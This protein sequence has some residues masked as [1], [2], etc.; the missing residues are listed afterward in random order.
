M[1]PF[2]NITPKNKEKLLRSL[3]AN[4]H[5]FKAGMQ[6]LGTSRNE[7]LIGIIVYGYIQIIKTDYNG[8]TTI[9]EKLEENAI[10][11]NMISNI[12]NIEYQ[13]ITKEETKIIL[14]DYDRL[15][16]N[17]RQNSSYYQFIQN[18]L[19]IISNKIHDQNQRIELL[20][21][22]TIRNK[23]LKY[24]QMQTPNNIRKIIYLPFTYTELA[25]YLSVDRS[26][27]MR[28]IKNLRDE[29]IIETKDKK[30]YLKY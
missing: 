16:T 29:G 25:E 28:E 15:L 18:I 21:E 8:N 5:V 13:V 17:L 27:L 2:E 19:K 7:N 4:T 9:I 11:G 14:I 1:N 30:I 12:S 20:T 23:L 24:F 6:I 26:A 3:E 22:K 10:F